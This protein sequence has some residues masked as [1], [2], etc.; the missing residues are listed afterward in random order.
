MERW[1]Q[2]GSRGVCGKAR[3][4]FFTGRQ[5]RGIKPS[6]E[7][8]REAAPQL[9]VGSARGARTGLKSS[10]D[11][12]AKPRIPAQGRMENPGKSASGPYTRRRSEAESVTRRV[13]LPT[14]PPLGL[15]TSHD[16]HGRQTESDAARTSGSSLAGGRRRM[17]DTRIPR[18]VSRGNRA[19]SEGGPDP[20]DQGSAEW[21]GHFSL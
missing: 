8:G 3:V 11:S 15:G 16:S 5:L 7:N 12:L 17:S 21:G 13:P 20:H 9:A 6:Q 19:R 2:S 10:S 18:G 1:A 14:A 4:R